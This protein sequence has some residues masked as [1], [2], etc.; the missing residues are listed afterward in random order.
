MKAVYLVLWVYRQFV[1]VITN[2]IPFICSVLMFSGYYQ[3][4]LV[5]HL[6]LMAENDKKIAT[7][8]EFKVLPCNIFTN[9]IPLDF[10]YFLQIVQFFPFLS[11]S[12]GDVEITVSN[13]KN[14]AC[15]KHYSIVSKNKII[16]GNNYIAQ[17]SLL[18]FSSTWM[19]FETLFEYLD[20]KQDKLYAETVSIWV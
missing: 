17:D 3:S 20:V 6:T 5:C 18:C 13:H 7:E 8:N 4:S 19:T 12:L 1:F 9:I 2:G 15:D 14:S 16:E 11:P 10:L